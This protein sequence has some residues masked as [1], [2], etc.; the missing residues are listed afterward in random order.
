[1]TFLQKVSFCKFI[2]NNPR[3]FSAYRRKKIVI[4][5]ASFIFT[6]STSFLASADFEYGEDLTYSIEYLGITVGTAH[7]IVLP[8]KVEQNN[9]PCLVFKSIAKSTPFI[10]YIYPVD[11]KMISYFDPYLSRTLSSSKRV[12]EGKLHRE[13]H[14]EYDFP[15]KSV[16]WWQKAHK[17]KKE[18]LPEDITFRPKSGKTNDIPSNLMDILS[19]LYYLRRSPTTPRVGTYFSMTIYDDLQV[20][21]IEFHILRE[22][23]LSLKIDS[24]SKVFNAYKIRPYL[25]TSGF[26]QNDGE[27]FIW[28]SS[29]EKRYPLRIE[30]SIRG[31]GSIRVVL[32]SIK[33]SPSTP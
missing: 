16:N 33:E 20:V 6:T 8:T 18:E 7:L 23:S 9:T 29:D 32:Q 26:F 12:H 30:S 24:I 31:L 25:S 13:Y 19:A 17:G 4:A 1:M 15:N 3:L 21:P 2:R 11:D 22:V 27:L 5:V 10:D 28:I 14:A